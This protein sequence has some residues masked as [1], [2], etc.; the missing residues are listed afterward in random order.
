MLLN[1][2]SSRPK[3]ISK[4]NK[5]PLEF[6]GKYKNSWIYWLLFHVTGVSSNVAKKRSAR[7]LPH[8]CRYNPWGIQPFNSKKELTALPLRVTC[9]FD[10][11]PFPTLFEKSFSLFL[12]S[13][14]RFSLRDLEYPGLSPRCSS[15]LRGPGLLQAWPAH[16]N[17]GR[18]W[19][20]ANLHTAVAC[21]AAVWGGH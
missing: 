16:P 9:V 18:A 20:T 10:T 3:S 17:Q 21:G 2:L 19:A 11:G 14:F 5:Q 4:T 15:A 1:S 8:T 7:A 13:H 12:L 6:K